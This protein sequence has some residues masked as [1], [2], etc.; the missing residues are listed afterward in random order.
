[1]A[2]LDRTLLIHRRPAT[3]RGYFG[4]SSHVS[5][6]TEAPP[7]SRRAHEVYVY[8][9][10]AFPFDHSPLIPSGSL[11]TRSD[12]HLGSRLGTETGY[13][14]Y[15]LPCMWFIITGSVVCPSVVARLA[16]THSRGL[17]G[18]FKTGPTVDRRQTGSDMVA[19][20]RK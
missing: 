7:S 2:V 1:M 19:E 18:S 6:S 14:I 13:A 5:E 4:F 8:N 12:A 10:V 11:S 9:R 20:R 16:D 15:S 3:Y 17:T